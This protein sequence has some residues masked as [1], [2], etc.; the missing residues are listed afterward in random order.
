MKRARVVPKKETNKQTR[1][2]RFVVLILHNQPV[3]CPEE[4]VHTRH[5][6]P[7]IIAHSKGGTGVNTLD[8]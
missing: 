8:D 1:E 7:N 4:F 5:L 3:V 6:S 2:L